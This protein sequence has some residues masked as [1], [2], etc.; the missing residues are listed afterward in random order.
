MLTVNTLDIYYVY[1]A[2]IISIAY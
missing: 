1:A 2:N